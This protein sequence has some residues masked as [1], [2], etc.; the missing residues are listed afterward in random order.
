MRETEFAEVNQNLEK[1][2]II[3]KNLQKILF[4]WRFLYAILQ[5][6]RVMRIYCVCKN[7]HVRRFP[8]MVPCGVRLGPQEK[9]PGGRN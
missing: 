5:E 7:I 6:L 1:P 8:R 4:T 3:I 9:E 2:V